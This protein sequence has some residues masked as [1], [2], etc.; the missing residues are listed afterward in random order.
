MQQPFWGQ[1]WTDDV[2]E[3]LQKL[4]ARVFSFGL[5]NVVSPDVTW[6]ST[7]AP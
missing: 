2:Y 1:R 3:V 7:E 5:M 6:P 4:T